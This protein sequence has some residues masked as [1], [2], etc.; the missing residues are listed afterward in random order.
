MLAKQHREGAFVA[1][2]DTGS[3][4]WIHAYFCHSTI[5]RFHVM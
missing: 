2:T 4:S 3:K 5:H 1:C